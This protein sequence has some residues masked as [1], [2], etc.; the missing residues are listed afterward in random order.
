MLTSIVCA[1]SLSDH[2]SKEL[3]ED[4]L[5]L[6]Q[7][8]SL[9]GGKTTKNGKLKADRKKKKGRKGK[10][11]SKIKLKQATGETDAH[12]ELK[13]ETST[14]N[15]TEMLGDSQSVLEEALDRA[16]SFKN[17]SSR[18]D[19]EKTS[20]GGESRSGEG[21]TTASKNGSDHEH[22]R[23]STLRLVLDPSCGCSQPSPVDDARTLELEP[24]T[25]P[26][27]EFS[28]TP[29]SIHQCPVKPVP[30]CKGEHACSSY[31]N[32]TRKRVGSDHRSG[33]ASK[34]MFGNLQLS[35]ALDCAIN[36][37]DGEECHG[38]RVKTHHGRPP[39]APR[40]ADASV[41]RNSQ[42]GEKR[43]LQKNSESRKKR[44][45][46]EASRNGSENRRSQPPRKPRTVV[47]PTRRL[48]EPSPQSEPN[49][50]SP[51][52]SYRGME[53][54][55]YNP[56]P[57]QLEEAMFP[58]RS[59]PLAP[60]DDPMWPSKGECLEMVATLK[61]SSPIGRFTGTFLTPEARGAK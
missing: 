41:D 38:L 47:A 18:N 17:G 27:D 1:R 16:V 55:P 24:C 42:P 34:Q 15:E 20:E 51:S 54:L 4:D 12:G 61:S 19:S 8:Q 35:D 11:A 7:H 13:N 6:D 28:L 39:P 9:G 56:L 46:A 49:V 59:S 52:A 58:D 25:N 26:A 32:V 50:V 23:R 60:Y 40:E 21:N 22:K 3:L 37:G 36:D 10:K 33:S 30:G 48:P 2:L 53:F 43:R 14:V 31:S 45:A 5:L 57:A 44:Q 29:N